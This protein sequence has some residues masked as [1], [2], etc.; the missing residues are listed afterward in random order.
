MR[1]RSYIC[2]IASLRRVAGSLLRS[3]TPKPK[4]TY[5]TWL[6]GLSSG[7]V[8][9][10]RCMRHVFLES[11]TSQGLRLLLQ[12]SGPVGGRLPAIAHRRASVRAALKGLDLH[13]HRRQPGTQRGVTSGQAVRAREGR[14]SG[15]SG[16]QTWPPP[17][18]PATEAGG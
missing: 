8:R 11:L 18:L 7:L 15:W 3:C 9:K 10:T 2:I 12:G 13:L 6:A 4:P 16:R 5:T 14:R 17:A 1:I